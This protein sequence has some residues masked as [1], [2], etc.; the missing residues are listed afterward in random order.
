M[1]CEVCGCSITINWGNDSAVVCEEHR[2]HIVQITAAKEAKAKE[3]HDGQSKP[4]STEVEATTERLLSVWWAFTWRY[5]LLMGIIGS[6][7]GALLHH[8]LQ[9]LVAQQVLT[10]LVAKYIEGGF[11]LVLAAFFIF[12][13]LDTLVGKKIGNVRLVIVSSKPAKDNEI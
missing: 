3:W 11:N 13:A 6:F 9:V 4:P 7:L 1:K 5:V 2:D 8:S 10:I 12:I